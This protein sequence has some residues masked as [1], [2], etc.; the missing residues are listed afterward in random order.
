MNAIAALKAKRAA[1]VAWL[2][3]HLV[4]DW[5]GFMRRYSVRLAGAVATLTATVLQYQTVA[6]SILG[7]LPANSIARLLLAIALGVLVFIIPTLAVLW[8]QPP[9][10]PKGPTGAP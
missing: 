3:A 2:D 7:S 8:K 1:L 9:A 4:D 10:P 5:R 6:L